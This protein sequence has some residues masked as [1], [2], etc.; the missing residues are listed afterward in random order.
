[1]LSDADMLSEADMEALLREQRRTRKR[2]R[3]ET[4][5][6]PGLAAGP[7]GEEVRGLPRHAAA[8]ALGGGDA[9]QVA[10]VRTPVDRRPGSGTQKTA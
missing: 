8:E 9:R 3:C 10:R 2:A 7:P 6:V 1:M 5:T 4:A